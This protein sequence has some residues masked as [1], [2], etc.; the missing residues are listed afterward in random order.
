MISAKRLMIKTYGPPPSAA[1]IPTLN[2][3]TSWSG[4][5]VIGTYYQETYAPWKAFDSDPITSRWL[6]N[7]TIGTSVLGFAFNTAKTVTKMHFGIKS[8]VEATSQSFATGAIEYSDNGTTW[9][10]SNAISRTGTDLYKEFAVTE[11]NPHRWWRLRTVTTLGGG[12]T[13]SQCSSLQF[14]GY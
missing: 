13:A 9:T 6:G 3:A 12:N 7:G 10:Q 14:Y 5:S 1:L 11:P 8:G 2:S 4:G